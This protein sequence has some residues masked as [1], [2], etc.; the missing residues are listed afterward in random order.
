[1]NCEGGGTLTSVIN[2]ISWATNHVIH[3]FNKKGVLSLSL[4]GGKSPS[5]MNI[6][7]QSYDNGVISVVAAGNANRDACDV[8]PADS[9]EAITV[10]SIDSDNKRSSFSNHGSCIDIFAPGRYIKSTW[11]TSP[12]STQTI[13]G[14]SMATPHV[15]GVMALLKQ[16]YPF[17]DVSTLKNKLRELSEKNIVLDSKSQQDNLVKTP[18]HISPISSPTNY[19]TYYPTSYPTY[20]PTDYPTRYPTPYPSKNPTQFPTIYKKKN[21]SDLYYLL[22]PAAI[23][24]IICVICTFSVLNNSDADNN[25]IQFNNVER[26]L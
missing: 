10:G 11:H 12:D 9:P 16:Q 4:G 13:S 6:L 14:T 26:R 1:L 23:L 7:K 3:N 18:Y 19:P 25:P 8:S 22:I 15:A 24:L 20:Y 17:A 5:L 21:T 2:G